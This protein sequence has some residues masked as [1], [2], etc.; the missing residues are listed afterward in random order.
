MVS[1]HLDLPDLTD[2]DPE[3]E[4]CRALLQGL[5]IGLDALLR[6]A[7]EAL[8]PPQ[9]APSPTK[10]PRGSPLKSS[11]R[12]PVKSA[13]SPAKHPVKAARKTP[14]QLSITAAFSALTMFLR[15]YREI[16][17]YCNGKL[18]LNVLFMLFEY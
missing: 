15:K 6:R 4:T 16:D 17:A 12:S 3:A 11:N 9:W 14:L 13:R 2:A 18:T 8:D 5:R 10:S 7:L 1:C